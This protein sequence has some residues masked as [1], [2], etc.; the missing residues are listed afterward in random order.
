MNGVEICRQ[1]KAD[2]TLQDIYILV[3]SAKAQEKDRQNV[4][5]AGADEYLTKPFSP[6][7]L[8]EYLRQLFRS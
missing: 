1:I 6:K 5:S 7:E 8:V 4:L 2:P 3:L